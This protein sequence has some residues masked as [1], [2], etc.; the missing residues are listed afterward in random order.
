MDFSQQLEIILALLVMFPAMAVTDRR[1][2]A[3]FAQ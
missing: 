1:P 3:S 2:F